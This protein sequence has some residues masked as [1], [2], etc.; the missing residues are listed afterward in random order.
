MSDLKAGGKWIAGLRRDTPIEDA[1]AMVLEPRLESVIELLH[2][3]ESKRRREK[4]DEEEAESRRVR[5]VHQLR[6]ATRRSAAA[7]RFFREALKKKHATRCN[8]ILRDIRRAAGDARSL[9]VHRGFLLD[10][11]G[12]RADPF[13]LEPLND[14]E[15]AAVT[16]AAMW[17][18]AERENAEQALSRTEENF[19]DDEL[20]YRFGRLLMT[21]SAPRRTVRAGGQESG[22][23]HGQGGSAPRTLGELAGVAL[24]R[25]LEPLRRAVDASSLTM[26]EL[27]ALR[28]A[29]KRARYAGEICWPVFADPEAL[30]EQERSGRAAWESFERGAYAELASLQERLGKLNDGDELARRLAQVGSELGEQ[31]SSTKNALLGVASRLEQRL[32][33]ERDAFL[34]WWWGEPTAHRFIDELIASARAGG[35]AGGGASSRAGSARRATAGNHSTNGA[36]MP[37]DHGA[38]GPP[39]NARVDPS[40][41]GRAGGAGRGPELVLEPLPNDGTD[42]ALGEGAGGE[43]RRVAAIDVGSNS[44]RLVV[45]ELRGDGWF[46]VLDDEKAVTRLGKGLSETGRM[47]PET[48]DMSAQAVARMRVIAEG[49]AVERIRVIGTAAARDAENGQDLVDA[50]REASGLELEI[51]G[52]SEEAR[53][54]VR[55]VDHAFHL[56]NTHAAVVDI[57]GG[58]TEIVLTANGLIEQVFPLKLGAVRLTERFGS[59]EPGEAGGRDRGYDAMRSFVRSTL[60]DEVGRVD[61]SPQMLFGTGGIFTSLASI[62]MNGGVT[63]PLESAKGGSEGPSAAMLPFKTRGYELRRSEVKHT[64]DRVRKLPV[65]ERARVPGMSPDRAEIAVAGLTI[66]ESVMKHLSINVLRVHDRGI[67]EGLLLEMLDELFGRTHAPGSGAIHGREKLDRISAAKRF[68]TA[69]HFEEPHALHVAALAASV[70]DQV[71]FATDAGGEAWSSGVAREL[72]IAGA[73]LHDVGYLINYAKHHK[74]SYHL[75][76]HSDMP[77]F[78]PRELEIVANIA[79]YHRRAEPK[80]KHPNFAR[81]QE[82]DR[83]IVRRLSAIARLADGLARSHTRNVRRVHLSIADGIA[84]F[85]LIAEH[86]PSVDL[87]GAQRKAALFEREFGLSTRFAWLREDEQGEDGTLEPF[88]ASRIGSHGSDGVDG[89]GDGRAREDSRPLPAKD[90]DRTSA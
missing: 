73:M 33:G 43:T 24:P 36:D 38:S 37:A 25:M 26:E 31:S 64:L 69:C 9:D 2:L 7:I 35:S 49:Y 44:I 27:H 60:R 88:S 23:G 47:Q 66:V 62:S 79:R 10:L 8:R 13:E 11:A 89:P 61:F 90:K 20:R 54:A 48:I 21:A 67:R 29:C 22:N 59:C 45:A 80:K 41:N 84:S 58:S 12:G 70:F 4:D 78:T 87:W 19:A 86:D 63:R 68:A 16:D 5:R 14:A 52:P 18:E 6:V 72:L 46:R 71:V 56:E 51:I 28:I 15:R 83:E 65:R 40:G 85:T 32:A 74:H 76:R 30:E 75:I 53:L 39:S 81:L 17:I 82:A 57:G 3:P 77:G 55:S 42:D 50:I 34:G 1:A